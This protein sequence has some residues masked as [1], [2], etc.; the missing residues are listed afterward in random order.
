MEFIESPQDSFQLPEGKFSFWRYL[1]LIIIV[2]GVTLVS[3]SILILIASLIEGNMDVLNFPPFT[4]LWVSMLPFA[5]LLVFLVIGIRLIHQQTFK[6]IFT[7]K[8]HFNRSLMIKSAI[9]WFVLSALADIIIAFTQPGNYSYTFSLRSFIPFMSLAV[10]LIVFQITAEEVFFRSY[11]L[12]GFI[13]LF[14]F[15]WLAVITQAIMFGIL[16]GANPEVTTYGILTTMPFYIG[17]GLLLGWLTHK[18]RGLEIALGLHFANN[19]YATTMVTFTGSAISSPA[20]FTIMDYQ[21]ETGLIAFAILALLF[22][23]IITRVK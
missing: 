9:I 19:L 8:V 17:I 14:R 11:L 18:F 5:A 15:Q 1:F 13:R 20:I 7:Q 21:P 6:S 3:Q 4:F 16:H 12:H 22:G 10:I 23:L 2:V